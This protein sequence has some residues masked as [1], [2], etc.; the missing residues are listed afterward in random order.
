[1]T[2]LI[3]DK[4]HADEEIIRLTIEQLSKDLGSF[5]PEFHFSGQKTAVFEELAIQVTEVL[6]QIRKENPSSLRAILYKIDVRENEVAATSGPDALKSLAERI[7]Q[8][9]FQKV[10]TRRFFS[11]KGQ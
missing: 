4:F 2:D 8:R 3:P 9:E 7:I 10:L 6:K 1:M 5:C 11:Q